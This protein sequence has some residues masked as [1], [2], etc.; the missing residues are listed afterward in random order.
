[1]KNTYSVCCEQT[2]TLNYKFF[3]FHK[4]F[5]V[6][7]KVKGAVKIIAYQNLYLY[8]RITGARFR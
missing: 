2:Y 6:K 5:R 4:N 8:L 3:A 7:Q 1:M